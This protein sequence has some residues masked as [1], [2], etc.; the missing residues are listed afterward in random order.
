M[1]FRA[2]LFAILVLVLSAVGILYGQRIVDKV[3]A[4]QFRPTAQVA[5]VTERVGMSHQARDIFYATSP[6]VEDR[7][8][9]NNSCQSQER[10]V[11]IL[12]CYYRDRIYLFNIDNKELDGTLEVTAAHEM[13][14]AAYQ[15]LN[16]FERARVDALVEAEYAKLKDDPNLQEIMK[17]YHTA[18]PGAESNELHSIIGTTVVTIDPEL[19]QYYKGY[20]SDRQ[21]VV[22]LN[23]AYNKVFGD[24][25]ARAD[26]LQ[27]RLKE[28]EPT[29]TADLTA[30][31]ADLKQL[32]LD[33]ESFNQQATTG[34][35][36]TR[37]AF[38]ATRNA[39]VAR[40]DAM[41]ARRDTINTNVAKY[42]ADVKALNDL[43]VQVNSLYQSINGVEAATTVE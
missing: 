38:N 29:I 20:F 33:I 41:N 1:V 37:A 9:F 4:S 12:G 5:Q 23:T 22:A 8:Q 7:A 27:A 32:E 14:H 28:A 25:K 21:Q 11:A 42:N 6:V 34:Y 16:I 30:Y 43:S 26:E 13:L 24:M 17:Y 18:E 40:V 3:K 2:V 35:Y 19:E 10:T 39:L 15:R 31:D 36:S